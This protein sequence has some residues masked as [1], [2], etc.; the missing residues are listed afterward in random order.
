MQGT[1]QAEYVIASRD[2]G[3]KRGA[4]VRS[5]G[6]GPPGDCGPSSA[7]QLGHR[8]SDDHG[9]DQ[10]QPPYNSVNDTLNRLKLPAEA[11]RARTIE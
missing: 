3:A 10:S 11:Y 5:K 7:K 8:S 4:Y 1:R 9:E 2:F 6:P